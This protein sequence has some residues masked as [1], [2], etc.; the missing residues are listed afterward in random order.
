[1]NITWP[2]RILVLVTIAIFGLTGCQ[3][4]SESMK[5]KPSQGGGFV[6]LEEMS[7]R[8]DLPFHKAWVKAGTDWNR[9]RSLY[10]TDV[11]TRY[12]LEA[13]WWQQNFRRD[14]MEN[15]VR[16]IALYLQQRVKEG[17][18][19]DPATRFQVMSSPQ[20]GALILEMAL[21]E[22]IP[23]NPV[24]E[25]LSLAAPYGS[26]VAV[27]AAQKASGGKGSVAIEAKITD[28]ETGTVLAMFADREQAKVGPVNLRGLTWYG[29][30]NAIIDDWAEQLVK[31]ANKRPGEVV[32]DSSPFTLKPW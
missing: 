20:P 17:F 26:G 7:K 22:L 30:A 8:E 3:S 19:K 18:Q 23:S 14:Q 4:T 16:Q 15:D 13:N 29:E 10:I 32:K 6:P 25:A 31:I 12:L 9:Y 27:S 28:A 5:A 21:I 24:M 2:R 1:M 11:S